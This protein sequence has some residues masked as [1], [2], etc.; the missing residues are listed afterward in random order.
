MGE[1]NIFQQHI[2]LHKLNVCKQVNTM[3]EGSAINNN[4]EMLE[5]KPYI[6]SSQG[7]SV[8][9]QLSSIRHLTA[10]IGLLRNPLKSARG[11]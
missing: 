11:R 8:Q 6:D 9:I 5:I 1:K 7:G 10:L 3:R 2:A 4:E